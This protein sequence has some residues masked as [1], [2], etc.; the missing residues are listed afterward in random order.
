MDRYNSYTMK[1]ALHRVILLIV[2]SFL[3]IERSGPKKALIVA[4]SFFFLGNLLSALAIYVKLM[5]L[6]YVGYGVIGGFG[7]GIRYS[8]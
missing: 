2:R 5:W 6:L 7:V 1:N 8:F 4:S 3:S